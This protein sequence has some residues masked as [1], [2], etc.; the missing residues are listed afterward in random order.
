MSGETTQG[1]WDV[2]PAPGG[3][4]RKP[5]FVIRSTTLSG[6]PRVARVDSQADADLIAA[7]PSLYLAATVAVSALEAAGEGGSDVACALRG[8][9]RRAD[10]AIR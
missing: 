7:A 9:L 10:G 5:C 4:R 1:P 8:A 6:C 2:T 3:Y